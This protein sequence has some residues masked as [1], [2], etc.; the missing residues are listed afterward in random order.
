MF[1][2]SVRQISHIHLGD[3]TN[4]LSVGLYEDQSHLV[5]TG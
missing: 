5:S 4:L 2:K 3:W 1:P